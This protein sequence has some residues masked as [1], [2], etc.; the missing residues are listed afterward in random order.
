MRTEI[1]TI[2]FLQGLL[3]MSLPAQQAQEDPAYFEIHAFVQ[4]TGVPNYVPL[5]CPVLEEEIEADE[6]AS[7]V[8]G[9]VMY[10]LVNYWQEDSEGAE[11]YQENSVVG[12]KIVKS[13][14]NFEVIIQTQNQRVGNRIYVHLEA[15]ETQNCMDWDLVF[16]NMEIENIDRPAE[17]SSLIALEN[18][19]RTYQ[20]YEYDPYNEDRISMPNENTQSSTTLLRPADY[21]LEEESN[22][23]NVPNFTEVVEEE[24]IVS[25]SA[26]ERF[27]A[28]LP[29]ASS[30]LNLPASFFSGS[31]TLGDVERMINNALEAQ[32]YASRGYFEFENGFMI[33]T[34]MEHING[35]GTSKALEYR[36]PSKITF[37]QSLSF[38][39]YIN[40]LYMPESGL[41][42]MFV[43]YVE[44]A[45]N[46]YY[47]DF[48]EIDYDLATS[49][50]TSSQ[51]NNLPP[52]LAN[53]PYRSKNMEESNITVL[54]YECQ[55]L[56]NER[57]PKLLTV[58]TF[59]AFEHLTKSKLWSL[60]AE[61]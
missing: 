31:Q 36:Y 61:R 11:G 12:W 45:P 40:S 42:R 27:S 30:E 18:T 37:N 43:F 3:S 5:D 21:A 22:L 10:E 38:E 41:F 1:F 25:S 15:Q 54:V 53:L 23:L 34:Q 60:F 49:S 26:K 39:N 2:L 6:L 33:A 59:S 48:N 8:I 50:K 9:T 20:R 35:N 58:N 51:L 17:S 7:K 24:N 47:S 32:G 13:L 28:L 57:R 56:E 16:S 14:D 4:K 29:V 46:E 52:R 55:T 19:E 44:A